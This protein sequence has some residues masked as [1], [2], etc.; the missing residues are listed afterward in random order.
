MIHFL[1]PESYARL[2]SIKF[3]KFLEN[4]NAAVVENRGA[5]S[6]YRNLIIAA[7]AGMIKLK[8]KDTKISLN[9]EKNTQKR[10][11]FYR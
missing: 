11:L 3:M 4:T 5:L 2:G 10:L 9:F 1:R 8:P 7:N 6:T